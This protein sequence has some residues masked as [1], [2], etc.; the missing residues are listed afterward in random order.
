M[1]RE[2]DP[3][4]FDF[5]E[6]IFYRLQEGITFQI[7]KISDIKNMICHFLHEIDKITFLNKAPGSRLLCWE[8]EM[9]Y[10][11]KIIL[12]HPVFFYYQCFSWF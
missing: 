6:G 8:F 5:A 3:R 7:A 2:G 11:S 12:H 9:I 1:G 4:V 10:F